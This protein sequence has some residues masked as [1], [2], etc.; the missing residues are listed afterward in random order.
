MLMKYK[1][2]ELGRPAG[3]A[4]SGANGDHAMNRRASVLA[5][6][7]RQRRRL[8][9]FVVACFALASFTVSAAPCFAMTTAKVDAGEH[10]AH[11][12]GHGDHGHAMD[13]AD[14]G[15]ALQH[16]GSGVPHCPHCPLSAAVPNHASSSDHSFCSA[17]DEPADQT[18]FTPPSLAKHVMLAPAF[19]IPPP[20]V[21]HPPPRS[22]SRATGIQRSTIALNLRNCV[23]LI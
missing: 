7:R 3:Q 13:H 4:Y 1:A 16:D 5:V 12:H 2:A 20:L 22:S 15:S 6:L 17:Y 18:F 8:G 21:F 14:S 9:R 19:E 11:T 23:L 10:A